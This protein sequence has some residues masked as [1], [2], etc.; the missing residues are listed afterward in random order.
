MVLKILLKY[1]STAKHH[2]IA[3][4]YCEIGKFNQEITLNVKEGTDKGVYKNYYNNLKD[5]L[6]I[7]NSN[8]VASLELYKLTVNSIDTYR[9]RFIDDGINE[10]EIN[11]TKQDVLYKVN[12]TSVVTEKEK[13]LKNTKRM[14]A[15]PEASSRSKSFR[16]R[17]T[18]M[19]K[20][21]SGSEAEIFG[22][23]LQWK[24]SWSTKKRGKRS[25]KSKLTKRRRRPQKSMRAMQAPISRFAK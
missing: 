22:S 19:T 14:F 6:E 13:E 21:A 18:N 15:H 1:K 11:Q 12:E 8:T 20:T 24:F 25:Q 3:K 9:E 5:L 23:L 2:R 17:K 7:G 4:I 10:E 16:S